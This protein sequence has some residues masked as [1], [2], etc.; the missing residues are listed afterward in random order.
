LL[1]AKIVDNSI[2]PLHSTLGIHDLALEEEQN[3]R[4]RFAPNSSLKNCEPEN[5][6]L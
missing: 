5:V 2:L 6:V 3:V 1:Y 4:A